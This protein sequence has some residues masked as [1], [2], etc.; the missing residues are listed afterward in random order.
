LTNVQ[1]SAPDPNNA[2]KASVTIAPWSSTLNVLGT[3]RKN[4]FIPD[5]YALAASSS[6]VAGVMG[7]L[8]AYVQDQI[9]SRSISF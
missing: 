3:Q 4:V 7:N 2:V 9:N 5:V 8:F 6:Y 1:I